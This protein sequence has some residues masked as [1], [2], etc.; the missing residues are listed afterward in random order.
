MISLWLRV[1][2]IIRPPPSI[3][4]RFSPSFPRKRESRVAGCRPSPWTPAY[5]GGDGNL[6]PTRSSFWVRLHGHNVAGR[7]PLDDAPQIPACDRPIRLPALA[8]GSELLRRR[9]IAIIGHRK[10]FADAV[11]VDRQHVW[12]PEMKNQQHLGGPSADAANLRQAL[13]NRLIDHV[14]DFGW[15][16]DLAVGGPAREIAQREHLRARQA[17][18]AQLFV[19]G[20]EDPLGCRL[21]LRKQRANAGVDRRR[22][23]A[24]EL[25]IDDRS[26]E[27]DKNTRAARRDP[28]R[29]DRIDDASEHRIGG[30]QVLQRGVRIEAQPYPPAEAGAPLTWAPSIAS[31]RSF[32]AT[33]PWAEKPPILP[34]AASTRWHGTTIG[35]GFCP[36]AWPTA[37]AAPGTPRR[38]AISP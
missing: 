30:A 12:T 16:R 7:R 27:R 4:P 9:Q 13:D 25:L 3:D 15:C 37:R 22:R 19:R 36:S 20:V 31:M 21:A 33:P 29:T 14:M 11:I 38:A 10:A 35:N 28:K 18:A 2:A 32:V 26:G 6:L 5:R 17:G 23:F 8:I 24:R 1:R 34:P